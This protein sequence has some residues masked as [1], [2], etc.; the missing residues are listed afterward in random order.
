[1]AGDLG[2]REQARSPHKTRF[3]HAPSVPQLTHSQRH[4]VLHVVAHPN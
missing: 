1:M 4:P 2:Q 3:Y